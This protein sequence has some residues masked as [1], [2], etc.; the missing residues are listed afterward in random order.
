MRRSSVLIL[1]GMVIVSGALTACGGSYNERGTEMSATSGAA[2][3]GSAVS[4]TASPEEN[5]AEEHIFTNSTSLYMDA[6]FDPD[7]ENHKNTGGIIQRDLDGTNPVEIRISD[8]GELLGADDTAVYFTKVIEKKDD[9]MPE[10]WFC[11]L[12]VHKDSKGK[13]G[14]MNQEEIEVVYRPKEDVFVDGIPYMDKEWIIY[15]TVQGKYMKYDR[16]NDNL[17]QAEVPGEIKGDEDIAMDVFP[18]KQILLCAGNDTA[19]LQKVGE[20]DWKAL[21]KDGVGVWSANWSDA[22]YFYTAEL[23][24]ADATNGFDARKTYIKRYDWAS[25]QSSVFVSRDEI[26]GMRGE[27][28]KEGYLNGD[29]GSQKG[30]EIALDRAM[31]D[32]DRLYLTCQIDWVLGETGY[33]GYVVFSKAAGEKELTFEKELSSVLWQQATVF[34]VTN[35]VH[36]NIKKREYYETVC[37]WIEGGKAFLSRH[38]MKKGI[39]AGYYDLETGKLTWI[40]TEDAEYYI[41]YYDAPARNI[42]ATRTGAGYR[43]YEEEEM[44][45]VGI[46]DRTK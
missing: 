28:Q 4:K 2:V 20:E 22:G 8:F 11:Q 18:D 25:G 26:E 27:L 40:T 46:E 5:K 32:G 14:T 16:K 42:E 9:E 38:N 19:Y 24:G 34:R 1:A 15:T 12:P 37:W 6:V 7:C 30:G 36:S 41:P 33:T 44:E 31:L 29:E 45:L 23:T 21:P 13:D 39:R 10:T 17:F 35:S 3:S 43:C